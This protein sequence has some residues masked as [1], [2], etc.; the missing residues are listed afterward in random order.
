MARLLLL[1]LVALL[2]A[3][4]GGAF[5]PHVGRR[6]SSR[7]PARSRRAGRGLLTRCRAADGNTTA[8]PSTEVGS[9]EYLRGFIASP[10]DE[11]GRE[12]LVSRDAMGGL[13]QGLKLAGGA[14]AVLAA[15]FLGFMASNGLL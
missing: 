10:L 4:H 15:L 12:D 5:G 7:R 2:L 3:P 1:L 13:D 8:V 11:A 9:R 6:P 14:A